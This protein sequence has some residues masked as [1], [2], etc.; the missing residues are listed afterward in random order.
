MLMQVPVLV[1]ML[2]LSAS[3]ADAGGA[4]TN[5]DASASADLQGQIFPDSGAGSSNETGG[6][7]VLMALQ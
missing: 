5:Q 6:Q 2:V 1:Q 7:K 4:N 3:S